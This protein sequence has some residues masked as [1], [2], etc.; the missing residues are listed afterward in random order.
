[1]KSVKIK[2]S[3][4]NVAI[5]NIVA[6]IA[7]LLIFLIF[8]NMLFQNIFLNALTIFIEIIVFFLTYRFKNKK[9]YYLGIGT[10]IL[11]SRESEIQI[12]DEIIKVKAQEKPYFLI[13]WKEFD[14]IK[15]QKIRFKWYHWKRIFRFKKF[16]FELKFY[17]KYTNNQ[18]DMKY[19]A[20]LILSSRNFTEKNFT[21]IIE[22]LQTYAY[23]FNKSCNT[24]L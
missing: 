7:C 17:S 18:K 19:V 6:F 23:K 12:S 13:H 21:K 15:I 2:D 24:L 10:Y 1:M 4:K 20:T 9:I 8:V 5:L 16:E 14:R 22:T 11:L 3:L